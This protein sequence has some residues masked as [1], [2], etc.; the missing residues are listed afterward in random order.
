MYGTHITIVGNVV[1]D[2]V[3]KP[4]VSGLSRLSFRVASTQRRKDN[5]TG[6][7][8]DGHKFFVNVTSGAIGRERRAVAEEGRPDL[9]TGRIFSRQYVKDE[10]NHVAYEVEPEAI[11][12]DLSRGMSGSPSGASGA[13]P[14]RS[15]WTPTACRSVRRR[16]LRNVAG[17]FGPAADERVLA[18]ALVAAG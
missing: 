5:A 13:S 8:M 11:G 4:T 7:W 17:D 16:R 10:A 1:D 12:H 18:R 14:A 3:N 2:V 15:S 6:Q 9:V